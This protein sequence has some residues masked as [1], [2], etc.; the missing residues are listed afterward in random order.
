MNAQTKFIPFSYPVE[1][2]TNDD[3]PMFGLNIEDSFVTHPFLSHGL[4]E[5]VDPAD[6]YGLPYEEAEQLE[7][8]NVHLQ[9]L[10]DQLTAYGAQ[11]IETKVV[12]E[13]ERVLGL[14]LAQCPQATPS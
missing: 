4:L 5:S 2:S 7:F 14:Y 10:K 12:V 3:V 6:A 11:D 13:A 8:M 9:D 1:I